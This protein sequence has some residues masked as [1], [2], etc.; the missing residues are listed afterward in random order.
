MSNPIEIEIVNPNV[1]THNL[2]TKIVT[3]SKETQ[4]ITADEGYYGLREVIV[5]APLIDGE[6]IINRVN[7][8]SDSINESYVGGNATHNDILEGKEAFVKGKKV[9]GTISKY[10]GDTDIKITKV[11]NSSLTLLTNKK[12]LDKNINIDVD[13]EDETTPYDYFKAMLDN[14]FKRYK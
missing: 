7:E 12:Y 4:V 13:L 9:Q 14:V 11:D 8:I 3:P 2:Q 1:P 6:E 10:S 5:G